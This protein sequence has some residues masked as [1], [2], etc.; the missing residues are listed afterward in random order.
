MGA[1]LEDAARQM[2]GL[3]AHR[4]PDDEG[5]WVDPASGV[6]IGQRRL[7]VLDLSP[8]GHQ[9]M[10]SQS[11]RSIVTFN[12]EIYNFRALRRRLE[13]DGVRFHGAGDTEVLLEGWDRWGPR[14]LLESLDGMFA[15]G[16][17]DRQ[18]RALHLVR[19]RMGEKPLYW[20]RS[21]A[22]LGFASE[23]S[24][25]RPLPGFSP[26]VD[27]DAVADVLRWGF[28]S[29]ERG[30]WEGVHRL[31][32]GGWLT[33]RDG[34]HE[35][36][37][38]W[39]LEDVAARGAQQHGSGRSDQDLVDELDDLLRESVQA[40]LESDVSL[41]TFLSGGVDSSLVTAL[42]ARATDSVRTFTVSM[43]HGTDLD[44]SVAAAAVARHLGTSH[45]Q[46]T[47]TPND[48]ISA[49]PE[50]GGIYDE[51][52][53]DPSGLAV[54]LLS[55]LTRQHVT[56]ALS[57]DGGDE[58]FAGYNRYAAAERVLRAGRRLPRS[59]RH[60]L[61]WASTATP[62]HVWERAAGPLAR[63]PA[64]HGIPELAAK[65]HRAGP[66]LAASGMGEAWLHLA[67]VWR[68]PPLAVPV[69]GLPTAPDD[70]LRAVMLRDQ[71]VTLPDDM[72]VKVDRASMSVALETRVPLLSPAVVEWAW[73]LP[74]DA[75]VRGGRGKWVLREVLRRYV[76]DELVDRPKL[77]FDPPVGAWLRGPLRDWA[78]DLL[79]VPALSRHGLLDPTP[80]R[81]AWQ[82]HLRG[83]ADHTYQLWAVL[84]LQS[85]L[86]A[87]ARR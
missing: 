85:W 7:A 51:P 52:F 73:G 56:V 83:R 46:L 66:V 38:W 32:P 8:S 65:V 23:M 75:L 76:P 43:G 53:A 41:G 14:R 82:R 26:R 31:A 47:L 87:P 49:V 77:G 4:G 35:I 20:T 68:N 79:S 37:R 78:E 44:E 34:E 29:G 33:L 1:V 5:L 19:D 12:G 21:G 36:R 13:S 71:Q 10:M 64:L 25:L 54:L 80:V 16:V 81:R 3:L 24:A 62:L 9:P 30:A 84:M 28:V 59:V 58:V 45:T 39:D 6:A 11:G 2:T 67:T 48:V 42:A 72:L 50:L 74:D 86:D 63:V 40:R 61:S 70:S 60:T 55:R 27:V 22:L 17:W 15:L 57:G 69:N 18:E